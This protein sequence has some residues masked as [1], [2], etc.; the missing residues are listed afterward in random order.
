LIMRLAAKRCVCAAQHHNQV[1]ATDSEQRRG[2]WPGHHDQVP[3]THKK[4]RRG[5]RPGTIKYLWQTTSAGNRLAT[6]IMYLRGTAG[7]FLGTTIELC[8]QCLCVDPELPPRVYKQIHTS[9]P[10]RLLRRLKIIFLYQ[11]RKPASPSPQ[12]LRLKETQANPASLVLS[13][14]LPVVLPIVG[15][16]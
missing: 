2:Q 11:K 1:P 7:I 4:Q 5:Q 12:N 8:V 16:R 9:I 3:A 13:G 14:V 15:H 6:T 10:S